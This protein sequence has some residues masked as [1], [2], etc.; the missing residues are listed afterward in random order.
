VEAARVDYAGAHDI[1]RAAETL[2]AHLPRDF[3]PLAHLALN[4]WWAWAPGGEDLFR[5]LDP[6]RWERCGRNPVR[7]LQELAP[8]HLQRL[9]RDTDLPV[10]IA[11]LVG[12]FEAYRTRPDA[13]DAATT[14]GPLAYLC[15]EFG[16]HDSL[17]LYAGGL[18]VLAGDTLKEAADQAWPAVA[19]GL[20]YWQGSF[21]QRLDAAG[22]QHEYWLETDIDRR[23]AALRTDGHGRPLTLHLTLRGRAVAVQVWRV[24]VG[25]VPLYLLDTNRPD[26]TPAD[27]WITA[28]LYIGDMETRLAQYALLGIG[29]VRALRA[30]GITDARVQ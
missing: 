18:G 14:G 26:N 21:H 22:L 6:H 29:G 9:A 24:D 10:R 8:P 3:A 5:S 11:T 30:L 12:A 27:R 28:R 19:V 7:L 15:A 4:Y 20:M 1:E 16:I 23:P 13:P 17:P 2:A 25:R